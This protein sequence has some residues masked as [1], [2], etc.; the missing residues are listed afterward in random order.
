VHLKAA[1]FIT[2]GQGQTLAF[3]EN[4]NFTDIKILI[5]VEPGPPTGARAPR[6]IPGPPLGG[7]LY[8]FA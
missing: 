3:F 5:T 4:F 2:L 1:S 8:P 6:P 7:S